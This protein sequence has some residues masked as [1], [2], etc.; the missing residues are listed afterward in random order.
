[1]PEKLL[2]A[3]AL[4]V[5]LAAP[6]WAAKDTITIGMVLEPPTLD[7]T[8]AAAAAIDEITYSNIFEGLTRFAPDGTILPGLAESW[9]VT[10][11]GK[12]YDFHLR[13]GVTFQDG[14]GFD[15]SD[16]VFTLD[17]ARAPDSKNAQKGLFEGIETVEAVTPDHVRVTLKEPDGN[18]PFK[19]AWGDAVM[20]DP[21][22]AD[23]NATRP[24]GTGPFTLDGWVQGD[25]I[26]LKRFDGYWGEKPALKSATFRFIPDPTAAFAAMMSGD[27]DAFPLYPAP[28]TLDQFKADPRFRVIAGTG[29]NDPG[30]E[31]R[32]P[33]AG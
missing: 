18:F 20:L 8:S 5:A 6:A 4:L 11:G 10:E 21:A 17:R 23:G 25:R 13:K 19:M 22:S 9:D 27:V 24:V 14:A 3:A 33:A 32:Q 2:T 29:R 12:V 1:M 7:P 28:E 31:Q 16:V 30:D 15:A 26:T